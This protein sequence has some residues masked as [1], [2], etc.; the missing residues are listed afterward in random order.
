MPDIVYQMLSTS[1]DYWYNAE[2]S[3]ACICNG[4]CSLTVDRDKMVFS[5]SAFPASRG[6]YCNGNQ[7]RMEF[8]NVGVLLCVWDSKVV[9]LRT[10]SFG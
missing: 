1:V 9:L 3:H 4:S 7:L 6:V 10:L 8:T 5:P 2:I